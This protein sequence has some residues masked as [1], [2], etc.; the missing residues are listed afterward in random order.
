MAIN[1]GRGEKPSKADVPRKPRGSERAGH[2]HENAV[3]TVLL[4]FIAVTSVIGFAALD[5]KTTGTAAASLSAAGTAMFAT[6]VAMLVSVGLWLFLDLRTPLLLVAGGSAIMY[7]VL[8]LASPV[9]LI[10]VP[11]ALF[12]FWTALSAIDR[13]P[14]DRWTAVVLAV[15]L[16]LALGRI[17]LLLF[18]PVAL[19]AAFV[20][21][22]DFGAEPTPDAQE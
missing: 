19:G 5:A 15:L 3:I 6:A 1:W 13:H 14:I 12:G 20:P 9:F 2:A 10:L 22:F 18:V 7:L 4:I 17:G 21:M 11:M 16:S 8:A